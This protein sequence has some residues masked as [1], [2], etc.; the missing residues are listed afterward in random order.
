MLF[1]REVRHCDNSAIIVA[2]LLKRSVAMLHNSGVRLWEYGS[3]TPA[4]RTTPVK[5]STARK[6]EKAIGKLW[7][8]PGW[9]LG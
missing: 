8:F 4:S 3:G 7:V 6:R 5:S 9:N 2:L 1:R